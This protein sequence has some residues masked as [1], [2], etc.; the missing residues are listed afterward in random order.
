MID[1]P[2]TAEPVHAIVRLTN[3]AAA[4]RCL[5]VVA[6]LGVADAISRDE[7]VAIDMLAE[8]C[9]CH[10]DALQRVLRLLELHGVFHSEQHCWSH[11]A[12]S[13]LLRSDHPTSRA[14]MPG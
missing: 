13:V 7:E 6:E 2:T 4:A 10:P 11:T 3:A 1:T 5:H 8:R 9:G 14:P 12:M